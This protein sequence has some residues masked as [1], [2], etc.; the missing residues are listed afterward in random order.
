M[1]KMECLLVESSGEN[2]AASFTMVIFNLKHFERAYKSYKSVHTISEMID[3]ANNKV[4][5][6]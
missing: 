5:K 3:L 1:V 6:K 2:Y 4:L